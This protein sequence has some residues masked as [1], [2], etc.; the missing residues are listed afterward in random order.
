[1]TEDQKRYIIDRLG[2]IPQAEL[3]RQTGVSQTA[4]SL[5]K[6]RLARRQDAAQV[7]YDRRRDHRY[8][9]RR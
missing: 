3:S 2:K 8:G 9:S 4:I 6:K 1:M 7:P 5:L